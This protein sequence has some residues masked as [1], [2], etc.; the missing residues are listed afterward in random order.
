LNQA[1][2]EQVS[3]DDSPRLWW[4][5]APSRRKVAATPTAWTGSTTA[6]PNGQNEGLEWSVVAVVDLAQKTGYALSAQQTEAGLGA[7]EPRPR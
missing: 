1:L 4:S 3:A 2:I 6:K 7:Q 5:I